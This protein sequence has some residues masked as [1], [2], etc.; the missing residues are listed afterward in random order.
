M[1]FR[2]IEQEKPHRSVSQLAR[3]LGV[4]RSGYHAWRSRRPSTRS[5]A[6]AALSERI[7]AIHAATDGIYGAPR[8]QVELAK[9]HAIHVGRKRVARLM[10]SLGIEGVA[11]ERRPRNRPCG[12]E[13]PAAPD[14]VKRDFS[15]SAPN[16]L[17]VADITYVPTWEGWLF[18][19]VVIDAFSR[20]CVGWSMRDDLKAELVVDAL[21]MAVTRRKP[22]GSVVH[23]SDRGSQYASLAFGATLRDSDIMASMGSRGD[24]F[25]NAAAE[26]FMAT[27]KKELIYRRRFKTRNA[28]RLAIFNY[29]ERFYNPVRRHST[30][31]QVSPIEYEQTALALTT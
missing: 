15:A 22:K 31:G 30:L 21:G 9:A 6:D 16:Q 4:S 14:L 2:L 29:I 23:H 13:A 5:L 1:K 8:I 19:A 3:V 28:A 12:M 20:R 17:W 24:A 26:S 18:L 25:D 7:E 27:I 10:R 11:A